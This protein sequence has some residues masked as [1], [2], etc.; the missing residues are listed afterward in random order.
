MFII[1]IP[2]F[3]KQL[4]HNIQIIC[5]YLKSAA[6]WRTTVKSYHFTC[7]W[8]AYDWPAFDHFVMNDF[9]FGTFITFPCPSLDYLEKKHDGVLDNSLRLLSI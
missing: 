6:F 9:Y 3:N 1:T 5:G 8:T 7:N 4:L 2:V